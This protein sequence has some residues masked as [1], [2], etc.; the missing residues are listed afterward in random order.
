MAFV[1]VPHLQPDHPS[2]LAEILARSTS[3]PVVQIASEQVIEPNTIYVLPPGHDLTIQDSTL[4]LEQRAQGVPHH[5]VDLFFRSLAEARRHLAIG[6]VLSGTATDGTLGV[7]AIKGA[8]GITFAQD[9]SARQT[10]MPHSA[11]ADGFVDFVLPPPEIAAELVR[12]S[13]SPR[14]LQTMAAPLPDEDEA[15]A[16]TLQSVKRETGVD[17]TDYKA[18]TLRRRIARRML[19]NHTDRIQDY[20]D[21]VRTTAAEAR[22]LHDDLLIGVTSFFRDPESFDALTRTA[23]Q[24]IIEAERDAEPIRVWVLGCSTGEEA[25]SIAIALTEY[26]DAAR[27]QRHCRSSRAMSTR[28]ASRS[29]VQVPIRQKFLRTSPPR[30]ST[31]SSSRSTITIGSSSPFETRAS[32]PA[33]TR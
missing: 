18:G 33:T 1:V 27:R 24:R 11:I 6:V 32:F 5:P 31:G 19:L 2:A 29:P 3:M 25:Y 20:A 12:I 15:V 9:D 28:R 4:T 10:S 26:A 7:R 22:A 14:P 23:F 17:F 13:Q 8:G 16:D 30:V 21:R